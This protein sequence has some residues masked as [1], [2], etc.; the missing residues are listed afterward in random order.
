MSDKRL[1]VAVADDDRDTREYLQEVLPRL[2]YEVVA[3]AGTGRALAEQ[4][5][6]T[7]PDLVITDIKM[8]EMDGIEAAQLIS[9]EAAIPIILLSAHHDDDLVN[10]ASAGN[11]MSYL[12]KPIGEANLKTAIPLALARFRHMQALT[13]EA[14]SLRQ[15]LEDRKVIEKA[16]GILMKRLRIDEQDA[17]RRMRMLASS[18]NRKL[19]EVCRQIIG[20]D[21]VFGQI[22]AIAPRIPGD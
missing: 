5:R 16:K 11:V 14:A 2:G 8:P 15:A 21:D 18:Q 6:A 4:V 13:D 22:E 10:R 20:V 9:R 1:R 17:F 19:I 3:G 7:R 12:V